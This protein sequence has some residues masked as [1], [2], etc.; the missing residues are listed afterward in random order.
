[1]SQVSKRILEKLEKKQKLSTE[2]ILLLYLDLMR[3]EMRETNRRI[4][5]TNKRI[6]KVQ[7]IL[8]AKTEETN[9]RIDDLI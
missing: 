9:K 3:K 6:D 8:L 5:D 1:M 2:D 7:E 4:D